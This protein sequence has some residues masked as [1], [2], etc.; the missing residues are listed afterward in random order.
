MGRARV[1]VGETPRLATR[2]AEAEEALAGQA[3]TEDAIEA[4]ARTARR[5]VRTGHDLRAGAEYRRQL[6]Y[7]GVKRCLAECGERLA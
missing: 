2:L 4:A 6:A 1:A 3:L 5:V 7:V